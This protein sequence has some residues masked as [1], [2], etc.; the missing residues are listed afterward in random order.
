MTIRREFHCD[1]PDCERFH[2]T[3]SSQ[4]E[5]FITLTGSMTIGGA[6]LHFC[7]WDCLLR[8][9][10]TKEPETIIPQGPLAEGEPDA[11]A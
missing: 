2:S 6:A 1:G 4:S 8:H 5:H 10:A 3:L 9:A 11:P 7:G